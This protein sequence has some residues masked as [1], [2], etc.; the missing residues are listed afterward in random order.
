LSKEYTNSKE[1]CAEIINL[2]AILN[3]PKGTE[4]FITD[5]HGEY[6]AFTHVLKNGSGT[7]KRKIE[8]LFSEELSEQ[9]KKQLATIIYYPEEKLSLIE[10]SLSGKN[11]LSVEAFVNTNE[12]ID[13]YRK[14]IYRLIELCR[15]VSSKYTRKDV[16]KLISKEFRHI[17]EELLHEEE[18]SEHKKYYVES[19]VDN[20]IKIGIAKDFISEISNLI[21]KLVVARLHVVGDI[22]DRGARPDIVMDKLIE[23]HSLDIQWGNHDIL[24]M[25]AASGQEVCI[26]NVLRISARYM[27]LDIIEDVYGINLLPLYSFAMEVY[28]DDPCKDF[29]PKVLEGEI[30]DYE[31]DLIAKIHKAIS[32]IQFKLEGEVINRRPEF[33]MNDRLLLEKID[34]DNYTIKINDTEYK[35]ND[36]NFPTIDR[37]NPYKLSD[38]EKVVIEKI[39]SSFK[40]SEKLQKHIKFLFDKG[41]IYLKYNSN[42]L[43]HGCVPLNDDGSF[44]SMKIRNESIMNN[45]KECLEEFQEYAGRKLMDKME[46]IIRNGFFIEEDC[47]E[48]LYGMDMMWYM[49]TGKASSLFGKNSMTT[50]ERYFIDDKASH[51][52]VKNPYFELREDE[53]ICKDIFDEFDLNFEESHIINGHV[54]V[55]SKK[56]ESPVKANGRILA[57]DGGFSKAYQNSTGIAGYTLIYNSRSIHIVAHEPFTSIEEAIENES[58]IVSTTVLLRNEGKRK[59]IRDTD[60]GE[61]IKNKIDDL[62]KLLEAYRKGIIR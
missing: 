16:R 44:M 22:Y 8:D 50:F 34:F 58:D 40:R 47:E 3:L 61:V 49:W 4:H 38:E 26:S 59:M 32:I 18:D 9:E 55:K 62:K 17:V 10:K 42:L 5:I 57:I 39:T 46:D 2:E 51:K 36:T 35:L 52:E 27:N 45:H 24:W 29:K 54:P 37:N 30:S 25:G 7:I 13:F 48:K 15:Y 6:E 33:E 28:K 60:E 56:G 43:L 53:K 11:E 23:H 41:S 12:I 31:K 20:I 1:V 14:T 19:I 21:Q